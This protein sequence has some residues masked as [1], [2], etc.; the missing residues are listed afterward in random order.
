MINFQ[1]SIF[2]SN[3]NN[4]KRKESSND[5]SSDEDNEYN[6]YD[7]NEIVTSIERMQYT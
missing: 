3:G 7:V 6:E 2:N 4:N 5:E 1:S